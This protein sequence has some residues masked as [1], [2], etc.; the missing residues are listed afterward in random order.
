MFV[1]N[2]WSPSCP[3]YFKNV[4]NTLFV[5]YK[6]R[7]VNSNL[8][9]LLFKR[10]SKKINSEKMIFRKLMEQL[11]V[12]ENGTE[13]KFGHLVAHLPFVLKLFK[14]TEAD[15]AQ[16]FSNVE[17][18]LIRE[19]ALEHFKFATLLNTFAHIKPEETKHILKEVINTYFEEEI[20]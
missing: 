6:N 3:I 10:Y 18:A 14:L 16:I 11:V 5:I 9:L 12:L 20:R 15:L 19:G 8:Q 2:A 17:K 4:P 13:L 7:D 1:G